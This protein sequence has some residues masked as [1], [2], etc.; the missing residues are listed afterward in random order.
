MYLNNELLF[1]LVNWDV[2]FE[3]FVSLQALVQHLV[4]AK[5]F[6][7]ICSVGYKLTVIKVKLYPSVETT[8]HMPSLTEQR[9]T[10]GR[11]WKYIDYDSSTDSSQCT[12]DCTVTYLFL[13]IQGIGNNAQQ[14][15][16]L[17]LEFVYLLLA[18]NDFVFLNE[19]VLLF[20]WSKEMFLSG[21]K[22]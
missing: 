9:S 12:V 6:Q 10:H 16:G 17:G 18:S 4:V 15:L 11:T 22:H 7:S 14:L 19:F 21:L 1:S 3:W 20:L 5:F 13:W 2:D 8:S